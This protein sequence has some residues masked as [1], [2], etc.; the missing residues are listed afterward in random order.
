MVLLENLGGRDTRA[1]LVEHE[2][3][4]A[5]GVNPVL[6]ADQSPLM[7][8]ESVDA[9]GDDIVW[10]CERPHGAR[11]HVDAMDVVPAGHEERP[12]VG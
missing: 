5:A 2:A 10:R 8:V 4:D 6:D 1:S 11:R 3:H 7:P 9:A 12:P